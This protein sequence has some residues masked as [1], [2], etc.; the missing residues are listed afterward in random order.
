MDRQQ[1][2]A[3][4]TLPE[5]DDDC[6][7]LVDPPP[8]LLVRIIR[9]LRDKGFETSPPDYDEEIVAVTHVGG[10]SV[11]W[12]SAA[13][14]DAPFRMRGLNHA[15]F[16]Y[17]S[18]NPLYPYFMDIALAADLRDRE[19]LVWLTLRVVPGGNHHLAMRRVDVV[20]TPQA[21]AAYRASVLARHFQM[22]QELDTQAASDNDTDVES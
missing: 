21:W 1:L 7:M 4:G 15:Q 18:P 2:I 8:L 14:A 11:Q 13:P 6:V 10:A 12:T 5:D 16:D 20:R 9:D 17:A 19:P 22:V 3:D